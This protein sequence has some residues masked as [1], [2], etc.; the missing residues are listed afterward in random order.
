M[1]KKGKSA[2][3]ISIDIEANVAQ[4]AQDMKKV[5]SELDGLGRKIT[6]INRLLGVSL[7]LDVF[8]TA[9]PYIKEFAGALGT[10]SERG[11]KF[12]SI[13]DAFEKLGGSSS[14]IEAAQKAV[15][16]VVD[17]FTLMQIANEGL[18]KQIPGFADNFGKI[19]DLGNRVADSLGIEATEGIKQVTDA[20]ATAKEKQLAAVGITISAD[21]AYRNY[22]KSVGI[23]ADK[24]SEAQKQEARQIAAIEQLD[25]A[26]SRLPESSDSVANSIAALKAGFEEA[27]T[28][29]G[30]G[31]NESAELTQ[32]LREMGEV[33]GDVDWEEFGGKL[34]GFI[35][36]VVESI[37]TVLPY[38][39]SFFETIRRLRL[40]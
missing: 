30:I 9:L 31:I 12:G 22:A 37:N 40:T 39:L 35:S 36:Q 8:K 1:A 32:A 16:G 20:L 24:L 11:E 34:A 33:I 14:Q 21:E 25:N 29:F 5:T 23:A 17:S 13:S 3:K 2:A 15:L 4:L 10:L 26:L 19:A 27:L 18:L 38:I 6:S 28:Q 7:S